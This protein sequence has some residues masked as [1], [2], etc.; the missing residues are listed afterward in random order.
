MDFPIKETLTHIFTKGAIK[1]IYSMVTGGMLLFFGNML[2]NSHDKNIINEVSKVINKGD[3][4][5]QARLLEVGQNSNYNTVLIIERLSTLEDTIYHD[6]KSLRKENQRLQ[7]EK[8]KTLLEKS[9]MILK[10]K[11]QSEPDSVISFPK[12]RA[13]HDT[14]INPIKQRQW[15]IV[16]KRVDSL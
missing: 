6:N 8:I 10:K 16:G 1:I 9:L 14:I 2:I 13:R 15:K 3:S 5:S 4:T 12:Q 11:D 7:N